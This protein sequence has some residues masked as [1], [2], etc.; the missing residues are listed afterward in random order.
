MKEYMFISYLPECYLKLIAT[1]ISILGYLLDTSKLLILNEV[2]HSYSKLS[3]IVHFMC[4]ECDYKYPY[5]SPSE[6][7]YDN[8]Y[9]RKT[10]NITTSALVLY[11]FICEMPCLPPN[12]I[13]LLFFSDKPS[14]F[15][16]WLQIT[17]RDTLWKCT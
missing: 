1:L 16:T 10:F 4:T 7:T 15:F 9:W 8:S 13:R 12:I 11:F 6:S 5:G 17:P 3:D 2:L 14:V